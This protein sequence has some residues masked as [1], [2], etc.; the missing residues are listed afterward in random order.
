MTWQ[1]QH[2]RHICAS[3]SQHAL[4]SLHSYIEHLQGRS[5]AFSTH[6]AR[7]SLQSASTLTTTSMPCLVVCS[8][9]GM[10]AGSCMPL[11]KHCDYYYIHE[12]RLLQVTFGICG[13]YLG[14]KK[15]YLVTLILMI[16]CTIG[17]CF[18]A[19]PFKGIG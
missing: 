6:H 1:A 3:Y 15:I 12:G 9:Q 7:A 5:R 8:S 13:D 16:A 14:R 18:A 11:R 10:H 4:W 17:Q 2:S 19:T